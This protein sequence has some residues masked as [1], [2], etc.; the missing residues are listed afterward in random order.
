LAA[1]TEGR[2]GAVGTDVGGCDELGAA[3]QYEI[4]KFYDKN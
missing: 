1:I 2:A 3:Y 4:W